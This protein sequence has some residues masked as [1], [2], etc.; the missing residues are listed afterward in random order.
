MNFWFRVCKL[1]FQLFDLWF[2]SNKK[3]KFKVIFK[4]KGNFYWD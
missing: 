4:N 3:G 2:I 1:Y